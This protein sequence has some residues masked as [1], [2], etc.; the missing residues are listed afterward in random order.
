MSRAVI[1]A[2]GKQGDDVGISAEDVVLL[3][4][5]RPAVDWRALRT[6]RP[7]RRSPLAALEPAGPDGDRLLLTAVGRIAG[8]GRAAVVNWLRRH[9]DFPDPVG[10]TEVHPEFE[11]RAIVDWLLA[12]RRIEVPATLPVASLLVAGTGGG[13]LPFH[14]ED[15]WLVLAV[16]ADG[17]DRLTA[18]TTDDDA[19]ALAEL[20]ADEYGASMRRL[21][22]PGTAPLAVT[23]EVR[24]VDRYR[25]GA[26]GLRI[27]PGLDRPPAGRRLTTPVRRPGPPRRAVCHPGPGVRLPAARLRRPDPG[28][29]VH[30]TRPSCRTRHGVAPRGRHH[31]PPTADSRPFAEHIAPRPDPLGRGACA[32]GRCYRAVWVDRSAFP[33]GSRVSPTGCCIVRSPPSAGSLPI[34]PPGT[35]RGNAPSITSR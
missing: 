4:V 12:H 1:G 10:G 5:I 11:V 26:G 27:K 28:H 16:D 33:V 35:R 34:R 7:G 22:A 14:L 29:L 24:A 15:P 21:T 32:R 17:E 6:I 18:W 20:A 30:R 2:W 8:V 9:D 3:P 31:L 25:A 19:D 13:K 23:G